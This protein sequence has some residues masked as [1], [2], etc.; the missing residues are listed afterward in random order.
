MTGIDHA[1][2]RYGAR[3]RHKN[4]PSQRRR[5]KTLG[6]EPL[7]GWA[8]GALDR[9]CALEPGLAGFVVEAPAHTRH[10]I[11]M[12]LAGMAMHGRVTEA[13]LAGALASNC[14]RQ[15]LQA[16]SGRDPGST[17][18]LMRLGPDL[19]EPA[20]YEALA[21][22]LGDDLRRR[23]YGDLRAPT[24]R[25]IIRIADAP[26][27]VV[28]TYRGRLI[29]TFGAAGILFV[30]DGIARLRPDL[31]QASITRSLNALENPSRIEHLF[32]RLIRNLALPEPP[33][34][35]T[36]TI[37]PLRSIPA[38]RA[39][40][41]R[42]ENCLGTLPIWTEA[43]SGQRAFYFVEDR[44][45][46]VVALARHEVFGT[47]FLH[48]LAKRRN[49]APS[50]DV[51]AKIVADFAAAGFPYLDGAPIGTGLAGD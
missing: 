9:L 43:I 36:S 51:K 34:A 11:A 22:V 13:W 49:G 17:R 25:S 10:Y 5:R 27:D 7:Y 46:A 48:S 45:L 35:G 19:F 31:T 32:A 1:R 6:L 8:A 40:G 47:W 37:R 38:L 3:N 2:P 41:V 4:R 16:V 12:A 24:D 30:Q 18:A 44:E 14:R 23:A 50:A 28:A 42:L 33:W 39:A 29:G 26:D 15:V 20:T 21:K